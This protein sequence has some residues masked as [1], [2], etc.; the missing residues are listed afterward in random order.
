MF[1]M[2]NQGHEEY[3]VHSKLRESGPW[4]TI[5][6]EISAVEFCKVEGLEYSTLSGSGESCCKMLLRFVDPASSVVGRSFRL[7]LPEVT[8]FPD[9]LVERS[10]YDAAILRKWT[11]RDKCQ[12]WWKNDGEDNGSWWDGRILTVKPKSPDFPESPWER[13]VVQYKSNPRETH[14]HSPWELY[15]AGTHWEQPRIVAGIREQLLRDFDKLEKSVNKNR[16]SMQAL[17]SI[18]THELV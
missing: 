3:I 2:F 5:K 16:V 12:V 9:F 8:S 6:G 1:L 10:R 11:C 18:G 7:T 14:Q 4:V 17:C 13:C 15:D